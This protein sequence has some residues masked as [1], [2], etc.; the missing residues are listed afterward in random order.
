MTTLLY[1]Q[2]SYLREFTAVVL[3]C[4]A[5]EEGYHVTLDRTAFFPEGGGQAADTGTLGSAF[6]TD[7]RMQGDTV[8]HTVTESVQPGSIVTCSIDWDIRYDRMQN[9][10]GEHL[11]SGIL[12][13]LYGYDNV[14]FHLGD[15]FMTLDT[16]GELTADQ[17]ADLERRANEAV[18]ANVPVEI[19]YPDPIYL[20]SMEYRAKLELTENVRIVTIPG[21]D[22]CACCA[23]HVARTGEIGMIR[24]LSA[25]RW[26]GGMRLTVRCGRRAL[27]DSRMRAEVLGQIAQALSAKPE[28]AYEAV[29]RLMS[30]ITELKGE[31]LR[32]KRELLDLQ[33]AEVADTTGSICLFVPGGDGEMLRRAVN[34]CVNRCGGICGA[35]SGSDE[36]GYLFAIGSQTVPL[37]AR[38]KEI[39]GALLGRGGGSDAMISGTS[40]AS[41][42]VIRAY[43]EHFTI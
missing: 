6:V 5:A 36:D 35:F 33:L 15:S 3:T 10:T 9:H 34:A 17:L 14:G 28:E 42:T 13:A 16:S 31:V 29:L 11:L 39:T 20:S 37:R 25:V 41:E 40:R 38:A 43:F 26:K 21:W 2:S 27:S 19:T 32:L 18:Y 7:V 23:P 24:I 1:N 12:H 22:A 30:N 8:V 4:E